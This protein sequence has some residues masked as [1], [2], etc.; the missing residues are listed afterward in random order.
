MQIEYPASVNTDARLGYSATGYRSWVVVC[1]HCEA[2]KATIMR[3][4]DRLSKGR[5]AKAGNIRQRAKAGYCPCCA[6]A[7]HAA[8]PP[9]YVLGVQ[10]PLKQKGVRLWSKFGPWAAHGNN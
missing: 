8:V 2:W 10:D 9:S 3:L 4:E 5:D 1:D 6:C 7:T